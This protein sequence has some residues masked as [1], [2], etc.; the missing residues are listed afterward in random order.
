MIESKC[1][2]EKKFCFKKL[3]RKTLLCYSLFSFLVHFVA[4]SFVFP[5]LLCC[6]FWARLDSEDHTFCGVFIFGSFVGLCLVPGVG[7]LIFLLGD[8]LS[9]AL[10]V[11]VFMVSA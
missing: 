7:V 9:V 8:I 1:L 2:H 10:V 11:W 4:S 3:C 5:L 6:S